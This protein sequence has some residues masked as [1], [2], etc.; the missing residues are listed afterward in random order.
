MTYLLMS[1]F[2]VM[3][4]MSM[5]ADDETEQNPAGPSQGQP[6][7][8][9]PPPLVCRKALASQAFPEFQRA[10]LIGEVRKCRSKGKQSNETK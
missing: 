2:L 3:D 7:P 10:N 9:C 6:P 1:I 5:S 8:P 4:D